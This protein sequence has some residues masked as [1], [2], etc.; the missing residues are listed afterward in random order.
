MPSMVKEI[1]YKRDS[2]QDCCKISTAVKVSVERRK[3]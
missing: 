3:N 1:D 2:T